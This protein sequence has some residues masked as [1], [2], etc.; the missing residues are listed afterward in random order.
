MTSRIIIE[1]IGYL[2]S[3]LI[4]GSM[5]MTSVQKLRIINTVGSV[6]FAS[7]ALLIHSIPTAI[8][9]IGLVLIN[10]W[11]LKKLNDIR[12]QYDLVETGEQEKSVAYFLQY[13]KEN[14]LEYFPGLSYE[15][16]AGDTAF[17]VYCQAVP[18]GLLIGSRG[19]DGDLEVAL[20]YA[21][22]VYRDCSVGK[23]LYA[24]L[25]KHGVR[26]LLFRGG[27]DKHCQYME[28][29]GFERTE[30]GTYIKELTPAAAEK[31]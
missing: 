25:P 23:Y 28:K 9:N 2:G 17:L 10:L 19:A 7:Y 6:I 15:M 27:S 21:T 3:I 4:L 14:I 20:D 31:E 12:K 22:P 18:A 8:I 24:E 1:G 13:Y 11:Q 16:P 5:L 29:M 30:K 26:R